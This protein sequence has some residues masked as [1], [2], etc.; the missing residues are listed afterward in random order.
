LFRRIACGLLE[1]KLIHKIGDEYV[2]DAAFREYFEALRKQIF[3][4]PPPFGELNEFGEGQ[5][6]YCQPG[7]KL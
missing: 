6:I 4:G 7:V 5:I 2:F 1:A 3:V